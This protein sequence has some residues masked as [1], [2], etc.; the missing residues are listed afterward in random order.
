MSRL[1][2]SESKLLFINSDREILGDASVV[3]S[4]FEELLKNK[5]YR[6]T[7]YIRIPQGILIV[8]VKKVDPISSSGV[9]EFVP[10]NFIDNRDSRVREKN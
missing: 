5:I 10:L 4:F 1:S 9:P 3:A 8:I 6:H 7:P 2:G